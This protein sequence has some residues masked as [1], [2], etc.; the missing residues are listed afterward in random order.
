MSDPNTSRPDGATWGW[1]GHRAAQRR[2]LAQ[3][4]LA[5]KIDWSE[6]AQRMA[7]HLLAARRAKAASAPRHAAK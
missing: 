1:E 2:R 5:E 3:L 7:D 6:Q 4:S